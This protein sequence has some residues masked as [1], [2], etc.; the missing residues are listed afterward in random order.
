MPNVRRGPTVGKLIVNYD[1]EGRVLDADLLKKLIFKGVLL[2]F[3]F[4]FNLFF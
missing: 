3:L 4:Q 1:R 2:I